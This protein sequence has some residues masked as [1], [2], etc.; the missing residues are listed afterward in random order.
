MIYVEITEAL[1]GRK[2]CVFTGITVRVLKSL[3][4]DILGV[5]T[6]LEEFR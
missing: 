1:W 2:R 6:T 5:E 4:G 3:V